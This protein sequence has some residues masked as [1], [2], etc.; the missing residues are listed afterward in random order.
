MHLQNNGLARSRSD[1]EEFLSHFPEQETSRE[2]IKIKNLDEF[3]SNIYEYHSQKGFWPIIFN[4]ISNIITIGFTIGFSV[5]L[6]LFVNWQSVIHCG[7]SDKCEKINL[8]VSNPFLDSFWLPFIVMTYAA[9]FFVYLAWHVL[10]LILKISK[11]KQTSAFYKEKLGT[12]D[13]SNKNM[14]IS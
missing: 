8:I 14:H 6:T 2:W 4:R 3:L 11:L 13:V 9:V 12:F 1:P 5:F 7:N 10:S